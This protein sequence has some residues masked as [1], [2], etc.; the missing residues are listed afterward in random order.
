MNF[1]DAAM[2]GY[3]GSTPLSVWIQKSGPILPVS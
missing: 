2:P 3:T 1:Q